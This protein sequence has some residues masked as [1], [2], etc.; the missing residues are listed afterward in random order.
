MQR[1]ILIFIIVF[2]QVL[3]V[4]GQETDDE[5]RKSLL[6][7]VEYSNPDLLYPPAKNAPGY[8]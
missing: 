7:S 2:M 8:P 3:R 4:T 6:K 5:K 1:R